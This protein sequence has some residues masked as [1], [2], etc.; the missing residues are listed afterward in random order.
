MLE[1]IIPKSL[2][3]EGRGSSVSIVSG[4]WVL[5]LHSKNCRIILSGSKSTHREAVAVD[6]RLLSPGLGPLGI[7]RV[8]GA[9]KAWCCGSAIK[10]S[11][12]NI[13]A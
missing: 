11:V 13:C 12:L 10:Q 9:Q 2:S 5:R 3:V 8:K 4:V 6:C 7:R 1:T